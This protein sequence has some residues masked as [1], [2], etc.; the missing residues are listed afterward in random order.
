MVCMCCNKIILAC[1]MLFSHS[2]SSLVYYQRVEVDF[3]ILLSVKCFCIGTE[4][5]VTAVARA[6]F[7][8]QMEWPVILRAQWMCLNF[9][10]IKDMVILNWG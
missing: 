6:W 7:M 3:E 5:I 8:C 10:H 2:L 1:W 9:G 4:R